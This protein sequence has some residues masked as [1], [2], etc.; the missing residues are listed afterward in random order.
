[1]TALVFGLLL[2]GLN[3]AAVRIT[4]INDAWPTVIGVTVGIWCALAL[5]LFLWEPF[6][7]GVTRILIHN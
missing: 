3:L 1:M 7:I 6:A 2:F 5:L 4:F